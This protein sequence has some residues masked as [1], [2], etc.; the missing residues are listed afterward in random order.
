MPTRKEIA[1]RKLKE[2]TSARD[3][4]R[5]QANKRQQALY[6]GCLKAYNMGLT[7]REIASITGLTE[8][9]ISQILRQ[10]R[11]ASNGSGG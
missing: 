11:E 3:K 1:R 5:D 7:Y 10:E 6:T 4:A 8:I 2:R 9:R